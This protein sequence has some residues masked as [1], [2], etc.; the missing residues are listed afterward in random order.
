MIAIFLPSLQQRSYH[1]GALRH[2]KSHHVEH[3]LEALVGQLRVG[4]RRRNL[5]NTSLVVDRR[6]RDRGAGVQGPTTPTT[7]ASISF[8]ATLR[9]LLA[10]S[11]VIFG[12]QFELGF[13]LS[14]MMPFGVGFF[15]GQRL[16]PF[17][18]SL[19]RWAICRTSGRR[20]RS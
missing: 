16:A 20:D 12:Q 19:P 4:C 1:R 10:V 7:L 15:N 11:G 6:C 17:S 18:L 5:S 9:G 13:L 14:T 3:A 8:W 2:V